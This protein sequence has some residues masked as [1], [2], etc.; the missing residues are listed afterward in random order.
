MENSGT[1]D[2]HLSIYITTY[3]RSHKQ[4]TLSNLPADISKQVY[5][6]VRASELQLYEGY[7]YR[8]KDILVLPDS[9]DTFAK[10]RQWTFE[11]CQ[12]TYLL[13]LD[14]DLT[15]SMRKGENREDGVRKMLLTDE[16]EVMFREL[17]ER[18]R[19]KN[20]A[21]L[22]ISP[23]E[24]NRWRK[25]TDWY[26]N[27]KRYMRF[28]MY[29]KLILLKE[30]IEV[31]RVSMM[32]DFDVALQLL[33]KGYPFDMS[34]K[35]IH[36]HESSNAPGGCSEERDTLDPDGLKEATALQ[37]FH[38][39]FVSIVKKNTKHSWNGKPRWDVRIAWKKAY[40]ASKGK[41]QGCDEPIQENVSCC[42]PVSARQLHP[43]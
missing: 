17:V 36:D 2:P 33:S 3:K 8:C 12:T 10:T 1:I 11:H 37:S 5:L 40:K 43:D 23:A 9:V 42:E 27:D 7:R 32:L 18:A 22:T 41:C 20:L 21:H 39:E 24:V 4:S 25:K 38:P 34:F 15:F 31:S 16:F 14:D 30:K 6:V 35:Y 19:E 28:Y 13:F 26:L 29:N